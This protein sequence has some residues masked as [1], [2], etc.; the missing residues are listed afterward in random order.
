MGCKSN[1]CLINLVIWRKEKRK[2]R[3]EG[4]REKRNS[5]HL[6]HIPF[7]HHLAYLPRTVV[8][9]P[10]ETSEQLLRK[11]I[12]QS[13]WTWGYYGK[14]FA[15]LTTRYNLIVTFH[16]RFLNSF[17]FI[18]VE[19]T[20]PTLGLRVESYVIGFTTRSSIELFTARR[21]TIQRRKEK[22]K[23]GKNRSGSLSD[24][25]MLL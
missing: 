7:S 14:I 25:R 16:H 11:A 8:Y 18:F 12:Y 23:N 19:R 22:R 13:V 1:T 2:E 10:R 15:V 4:K 5:A 17:L 6:T 9:F 3:G 21:T 24:L 20:R